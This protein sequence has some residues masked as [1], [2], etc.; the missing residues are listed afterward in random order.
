MLRSLCDQAKFSEFAI[1]RM[2]PGYAAGVR[3]LSRWESATNLK[4]AVAF[5]PAMQKCYIIDTSWM[6]RPTELPD[7]TW[8]MKDFGRPELRREIQEDLAGVMKTQRSNAA[9][10]GNKEAVSL[11]YA[12]DYAQ[13]RADFRDSY[14]TKLIIAGEA[15]IVGSGSSKSPTNTPS[16]S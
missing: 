1:S 5:F 11:E 4:D 10:L 7:R 13:F 2:P 16:A 8:T 6:P 14:G 9:L 12:R 15:L 3:E